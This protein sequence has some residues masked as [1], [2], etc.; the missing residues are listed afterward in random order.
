MKSFSAR[1]TMLTAVWIAGAATAA[2][3]QRVPVVQ[4]HTPDATLDFE[5]T[6]V[7]AVR[8]LR[9]GRVLIADAGDTR[10][11]LADLARNTVTAVGRS[12]QG[13]NEYAA[14]G[15][16][17]A[18]AGDS[19]LLVDTRG[20]RWLLLDGASVAATV[21]ADNPAIRAGGRNPL[22]ADHGG[23]ILATT[24]GGALEG[25]GTRQTTAADSLWVLR[26]ARTSGAADTVAKLERGRRGLPRARS[27]SRF[28]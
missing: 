3:A 8:P 17:F 4:L 11:V 7:S 13:P 2:R 6:R 19:T 21:A 1:D 10:L 26:L 9:D 20:G 27:A 16:L 12:G 22:G 18:L 5:F 15:S 25:T 24:F 28:S 23:H 14:L